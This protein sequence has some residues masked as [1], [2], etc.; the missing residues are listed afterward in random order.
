M[1]Q[2]LHTL[3]KDGN[4]GTP[5]TSD[6]PDQMANKVFVP[7]A[8]V[9]P[10]ALKNGATVKANA[11]AVKNGVGTAGDNLTVMPGLAMPG[12]DAQPQ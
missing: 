3:Y 10:M 1:L 4:I 5:S 9:A 8:M 2:M 11:D 12:E 6:T 7:A